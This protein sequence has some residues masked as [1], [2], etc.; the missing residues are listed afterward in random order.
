MHSLINNVLT[1]PFWTVLAK[2][3]AAC[4]KASALEQQTAAEQHVSLSTNL[5]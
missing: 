4:I 2:F 1:E 5:T 3:L